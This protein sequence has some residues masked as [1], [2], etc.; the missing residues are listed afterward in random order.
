MFAKSISGFLLVSTQSFRIKGYF[1]NFGFLNHIDLTFLGYY[2]KTKHFHEKMPIN[3]ALWSKKSLRSHFNGLSSWSGFKIMPEMMLKFYLPCPSDFSSLIWTLLIEVTLLFCEI[4][5]IEIAEAKG[6][7]L[8]IVSY[9]EA[10]FQLWSIYL[11]TW[12][13]C[14]SIK[15]GITVTF[16]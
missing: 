16:P 1:L 14:Y 12:L 13:Q 6:I 15:S 4:L 8:S 2:F 3:S 5:G 7:F 11:L 9:F 10:L